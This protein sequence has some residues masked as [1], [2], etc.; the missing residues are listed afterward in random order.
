MF[1][2]HH[3][4]FLGH[5]K[6]FLKHYRVSLDPPSLSKCTGGG[7]LPLHCALFCAFFDPSRTLFVHFRTPWG[8]LLCISAPL[9]GPHLCISCAWNCSFFVFC[10]FLCDPDP[11]GFCACLPGPSPPPVHFYAV[12]WPQKCTFC[13][14][15]Q[16][17]TP[18]SP[19]GGG[20]M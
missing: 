14:F 10:A 11:P 20:M 6:L 7:G 5:Q 4:V 17:P 9:G 15:F 18:P 13:A 12:Q 8:S 1:I 16:S 2:E 19:K 3:L